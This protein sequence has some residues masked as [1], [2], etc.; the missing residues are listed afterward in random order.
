MDANRISFSRKYFWLLAVVAFCLGTTPFTVAAVS[1]DAARTYVHTSEDNQ[2]KNLTLTAGTYTFR[3]DIEPE[4]G[5]H[6]VEWYN[7][8]SGGSPVAT[9]DLYYYDDTN[10]NLTTSGWVRA[11][12]YDRTIWGNKGNWEASYR[13]YVTVTVPKP[14]LTVTSMK[15]DGSTSSDQHFQPGENVRLDFQGYNSGD[16]TSKK[17]IRMKWWYGTSSYAKTYEISYGYLGTYNGLSPNEYEWETDAS[18]SVPTTP[19]TYY[20][21]VKIDDNNQQTNEKSE[22]NNEHTLRF[23]VDDPPKPDLVA[24]SI[25]VSDTT[26]DPGQSVTVYW[27]AKNKGDAS[28]G[29]SQQ[30]V[31]WSTDSTI[32]T[33]DTLREKE[34]L[35]SMNAGETTPE[36][37]T[38]TIPSNATPGN[39]YYI[40]IIADY[41][42]DI[43]N[44]ASESNNNDGTPVAITINIPPKPDLIISS[45]TRSL[46]SGYSRQSVTISSVT[47]NNG[48]ADTG[49]Y[50]WCHVRYYLGRSS[51]ELWREIGSGLTPNTLEI[52]GISVGEEEPDSITW[53]IDSDLSPDR[54]YITAVADADNE[55]IEGASAEGNNKSI[56][57]TFDVIAQTGDLTATLRNVGD[58]DLPNGGTPKF[59]LYTSPLKTQYGSP[60]T[61]GGVPTG[62]YLLEGYFN[63]NTPFNVYEFWNSE[64]ATIGQGANSHKLIRKYPFASGSQVWDT[65][66][67]EMLSPTDEVPLGNTIQF[68]VPVKSN[69]GFP[70]NAKLVLW[71]DTNNDG[72]ADI[73]RESSPAQVPSQGVLFLRE[74]NTTDIGTG[75]IRYAPAVYTQMDSG[76][77]RC[78][79]SWDWIGAC[80]ISDEVKSITITNTNLGTGAQLGIDETIPITWDY[81]GNIGTKVNIFYKNIATDNNWQYIEQ[82]P[83]DDKHYDWNPSSKPGNLPTGPYYQIKV[84][85]AADPTI[86]DQSPPSPSETFGLYTKDYGVT[87]ITHG[88][89]NEIITGW[90]EW[91]LEMG[92]AIIER[93]GKGSLFLYNPDGGTWEY[94]GN[95]YDKIDGGSEKF[96]LIPTSSD[97]GEIVLV[98]DWYTESDDTIGM[99]YSE[100]AGDAMFA[101]LKA[102]VFADCPSG[103][104]YNGASLFNDLH[105]IGHSRGNIVNSMAIRR[106]LKYMP[107]NTVDQVTTLDPH[108]EYNSDPWIMIWENTDFADNYFR[109]DGNYIPDGYQQLYD[110]WSSARLNPSDWKDSYPSPLEGMGPNG[111][112]D[113][114]DFDGVPVK[115]AYNHYLGGVLGTGLDIQHSKVHAWY[116][117][118]IDI[119]AGS[120]DWYSNRNNQGFYYSRLG[121]GKARRETLPDSL[122]D[123]DNDGNLVKVSEIK[124]PAEDYPI[125]T[126]FNGDF[127]YTD[128]AGSLPG[129][130][131]H[132]GEGDSL[133]GN[134]GAVLTGLIDADFKHNRLFVPQDV[135][136]LKFRI[137]S[138]Y[139]GDD[140]LD[141]V[142]ENISGVTETWKSIV[143]S[144]ITSP[145]SIPIENHYKG[146]SG[147]IK[148]DINPNGFLS[149]TTHIDDIEFVRFGIPYPDMPE[150]GEQ[151]V[152]NLTPEFQWNVENPPNGY[153]GYQLRVQSNTEGITVYDTGYI[154]SS[155]M[156]HTYN[157]GAYS[158]YDTE[159]DCQKY[160]LP[161]QYGHRYHW[162][163]RYRDNSGNWSPWSADTSGGHM[164]FYPVAP[165][166]HSPVLNNGGVSPSNGD[167]ETDFEFT[168][169]YY[170][171]DGDAPQ[172]VNVHINDV[173]RTMQLKFGV[174]HNGTYS[175]TTTL[176]AGSYE[177]RF[178]T[179]DTEN[180]YAETDY[181]S[182]PTVSEAPQPSID[183]NK[184]DID[185]GTSGQDVGFDIWN[186]GDV[187]LNYSVE[188]T[189]GAAYF[190]VS[191]ASG[192]S[193]GTSDRNTHTVYVNRDA[194]A[195]GQIV[196]GTIRISAPDADD[197]PHYISLS[198]SKAGG[199]IYTLATSV[200]GGNGTISTGGSYNSGQVVTVTANPDTDYRV[201]SWTGTDNDSSTANNNAVTMT[202]HKAVTV[203]F[204]LI[205]SSPYLSGTLIHNGL[206]M[207]LLTDAQPTFWFRNEST[208]QG[209]DSVTWSYNNLTGEYAFSGL[210]M[211]RVGISINYH[212]VGEKN[213]YPGNYQAFHTVDLSG[214]SSE[215]RMDYRIN[216]PK[217]IHMLVPW[218]NSQADFSTYEPYPVQSTHF[219]AKWDMI[220]GAS[221]YQI[222]ISKYR[223]P[224]HP[225]G[226]GFIENV[227]SDQVNEEYISDLLISSG[228]GDHYEFSVRAYNSINEMIGLYMTTYTN[229]YGWDYRFKA[230]DILYVDESNISGT[231]DGSLVFPF[232]TIQRG[233]DAASDGAEVVVAAG[234]YFENIVMKDGVDIA[235]AGADITTIDA[236]GYRDVVDARVNN[237]AISGFTLRNSGQTDLGHVNCGVYINGNYK[238]TVSNNI[239]I[240]NNF[241]IGIWYDAMPEIKNNIIKANFDG[242][243]IYGSDTKPCKPYIIN[244]TIVD[245]ERAALVLREKVSPVIANNIITRNT[246]GIHYSYV[247]GVPSLKYN[248]LW[249]NGIDYVCNNQPDITL[250]GTGDIFANPLFINADANNFHLLPDS[251]CIDAGDPCSP[252]ETEPL[253]NGARVNIGAYG[254]T[255][256]ATRSRASLQFVGFSVISKTRV[257]RTTFRYVLSLSLNNTTSTD[258]TNVTIKLIDADEQVV[259]VIDDEIFFPSIGFQSTANSNNFSDYFTIDVDRSY[260]IS[261]GRLTWQIDHSAP[262]G[263]GMQMMSLGLPT[264][265]GEDG[266]VGDITGEGDVNMADLM[267]LA[268]KWLWTGT[269]GSIDEDIAPHPDGDGIVNFLDFALMAENWM[270]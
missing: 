227:L 26:V 161:L 48:D 224:D 76:A 10:F 269:P 1:P 93:A 113:D 149:S 102:S 21:T 8:Y 83:A 22:S 267:R 146:Q 60:T 30:G 153:T 66:R 205:I 209:I 7:T 68:K 109:C 99:G 249:N 145:I 140:E 138:H 130:G 154:S 162:H 95:H 144:G 133:Y 16:A 126:V 77:W 164:Y 94:I 252:W 246:N 72:N 160:S 53:E 129:Y 255:S 212:I 73:V 215:Q 203:E 256:E 169:D 210:P 52:N 178:G 168:V 159:T 9:A 40:G 24:Y 235:G 49:W 39:T 176:P 142:F 218:D 206:P 223:D 202:D 157:P 185:M 245:N 207:R 61:F 171:Q 247:T 152:G 103:L 190:S 91:T 257:G 262:L 112:Q 12:L 119:T 20:L 132:G 38:I 170:D 259:S 237:A 143:L 37:H 125:S 5:W 221:Y 141:I 137:L 80:I 220:P 92:S 199:V 117:G 194:L 248:N 42:N 253:P 11:E 204:E 120:N 86:S 217:I 96:S 236:Q 98:F 71:I 108:P 78:T 147:T 180:G 219:S 50:K 100:A 187:T 2:T 200:I 211:E 182:G 32:S 177:Y 134:G 243:Y 260:V 195:A 107:T 234:V 88:W 216:I 54:Y 261:K 36:A 188:V 70:L 118:T 254:N 116:Q 35:G 56:S 43:T 186:D 265:L 104:N 44:E 184:S 101:S 158:G 228:N 268:E 90:P 183:K 58:S 47:K 17:S 156:T 251:L 264:A 139:P 229:G 115:G 193:T 230:E 31:M 15:I 174:A 241:G 163:V 114:L 239:I 208:G 67:N 6:I 192:S 238:P 105:F 191:P 19:G 45:L 270:K 225:D 213:T 131:Y 128:F 81:T 51:G 75:Q 4:H 214:L 85:S 23:I 13:W 25:S 189:N 166:N 33:S 231:E 65:T 196:T 74:F 62:T 89:Q 122:S 167:T 111:Y 198:A 172:Y 27:T 14:D 258:M 123:R 127:R 181:K 87:V 179:R 240:G 124:R 97:Q 59:L 151:L 201:K 41:D 55:I 250:A 106:I 197:N 34:Y 18:W 82:V 226:Y 222:T 136:A 242:F 148:F 165:E 173:G 244:N 232:S 28:C 29:S 69:L 175:Y 46:S 135:I 233:I 155:A 79:D 150:Q 266:V 84:S 57:L 64:Q 63:G 110:Y 121:G 263:S 3:T